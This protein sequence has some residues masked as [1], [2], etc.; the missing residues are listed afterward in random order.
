MNDFLIDSTGDLLIQD[1]DLVIGFS[2]DQQQEIL[3]VAD[4]G[5]F[6]ENPQVGVGLQS[7]LE[8]EDSADLLAEIRRQ[9][10]ADGMVIDSLKDSNGQFPINAHY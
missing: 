2:D 3:L 10:T 1:G 4:K 8:S 6:K 5:S 9:F 7:Y